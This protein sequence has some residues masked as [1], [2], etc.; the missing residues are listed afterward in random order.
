MVRDH[1]ITHD[2]FPFLSFFVK[3][4]NQSRW[5]CNFFMS[6]CVICW[7]TVGERVKYFDLKRNEFS[8]VCVMNDSYPNYLNLSVISTA[9]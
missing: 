6:L 7:Q 5:K 3:K 1:F 8:L 2:G 4:Y 9:N